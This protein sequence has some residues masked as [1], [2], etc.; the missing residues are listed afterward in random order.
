MYKCKNNRSYVQKILSNFSFNQPCTVSISVN[1]QHTIVAQSRA[2]FVRSKS[3][4]NHTFQ[5]VGFSRNHR[6]ARSDRKMNKQKP[7]VLHRYFRTTQRE[8]GDNWTLSLCM[9]SLGVWGVISSIVYLSSWS[10]VGVGLLAIVDEKLCQSL[11]NTTNY[12]HYRNERYRQRVMCT[13]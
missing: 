8:R 4:S 6:G 7:R 3:V 1:P 11:T 13:L 12:R 9:T 2:N 10:R 5:G